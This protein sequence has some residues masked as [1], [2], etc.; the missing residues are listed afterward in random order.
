MKGFSD[1]MAM[2]GRPIPDD[3]LIDYIIVGLGSQFESL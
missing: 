2:V 3:E 1:T